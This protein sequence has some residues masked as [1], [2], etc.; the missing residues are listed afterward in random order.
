MS[1]LP[2][3]EYRVFL[4]TWDVY[5]LVVQ[6]SS[7]EAAISKAEALYDSEGI[8]ALQHCYSGHDGFRSMEDR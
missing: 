5:D 2:T 6:A 3:R 4:N 1:A 7:E 8:D